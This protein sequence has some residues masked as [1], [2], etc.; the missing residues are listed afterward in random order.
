[1]VRLSRLS[2]CEKDGQKQ[3]RS[4]CN[5]NEAME[6]GILRKKPLLFLQRQKNSSGLGIARRIGTSISDA[7]GPR[8]AFPA[9]RCAA[10]PV[11]IA[12]R[13]VVP[14]GIVAPDAWFLVLAGTLCVAV[15][16]C[17][18]VPAV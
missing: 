1:M 14:A 4:C 16:A 3:E 9:A 6:Q 18:A 5:A 10:V 8:G 11:L 13:A 12:E 17:T 7:G 15:Q 2:V